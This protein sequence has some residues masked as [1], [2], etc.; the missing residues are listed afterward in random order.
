MG[1][2]VEGK[3]TVAAGFYAAARFDALRF[4]DITNSLGEAHTWDRDV[5]R[6]EVGGGYR[7]ERGTL[8]KAVWQRHTARA[9][10]GVPAAS[11]DIFGAQ[12]SLSF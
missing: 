3:L 4:G 5:D 8:V 9:R 1:G 10:D 2:Y 12:L 6:F 11:D 7:L